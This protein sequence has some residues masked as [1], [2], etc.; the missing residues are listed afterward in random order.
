M[1]IFTLLKDNPFQKRGIFIFFFGQIPFS[2][3]L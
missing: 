3:N 2:V 1:I